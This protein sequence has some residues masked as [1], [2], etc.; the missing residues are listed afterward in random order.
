MKSNPKDKSQNPA[1]KASKPVI[2]VVDD[3]SDCLKAYSALAD[4]LGC[5]THVAS[6]GVQALEALNV[7]ASLDLVLLDLDMP[8]M[9]GVRFYNHYRKQGRHVDARIIL[10]SSHPFA[11]DIAEALG[12]F[13]CVPKSRPLNQLQEAVVLALS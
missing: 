12:F 11:E 2:L 1:K 7:L 5:K 6:N 4:S 9:N 10:T 8:V 13:A 3:N